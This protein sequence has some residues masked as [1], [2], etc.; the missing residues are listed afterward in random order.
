VPAITD[1]ARLVDYPAVA[2]DPLVE[3]RPGTNGWTCFADWPATPGNDP[4]CFDKTWM[5][6]SDAFAA[7]QPPNLSSPG[8]AYMLQG[9]SDAS[10]TDPFAMEPA[11]GDDWVTSPSHI[12]LV[13]P[14]KLDPA[15]FS[16][17]HHSGG[18]YIMF[19]GTPYEHLMIPVVDLEM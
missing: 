4:Q 7:N 1:G 13:V 14:G 19:A 2:T 3:L 10:N 11:P 17:D 6:W 12:M 16:T 5:Q 18:P 8:I 9:G 15:L